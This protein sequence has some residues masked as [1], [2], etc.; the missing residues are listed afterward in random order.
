MARRIKGGSQ[1]ASYLPVLCA[2]KTMK[3]RA[4][5]YMHGT[6]INIL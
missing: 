2:S 4:K 6:S 5:S 1:A 3:S